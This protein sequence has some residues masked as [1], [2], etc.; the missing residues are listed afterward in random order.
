MD[1]LPA[2]ILFLRLNIPKRYIAFSNILIGHSEQILVLNAKQYH[3][4]VQFALFSCQW[5]I[6]RSIPIS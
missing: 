3:R 1:L 4:G 2:T 5:S 6:I